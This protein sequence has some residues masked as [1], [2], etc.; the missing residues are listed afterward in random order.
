[1][2]KG[3]F[4]SILATYL[5]LLGTTGYLAFFK[6]PGTY[7]LP[8]PEMIQTLASDSEF[9]TD[10]LDDVK[11]ARERDR[12]LIELAAQSFN[13]ILGAMLG[14]LSAI[15]AGQITPRNSNNQS[16]SDDKDNKAP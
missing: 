12:K 6:F 16:L 9:K 4:V 15:A 11:K 13:V 10:L 5:M 7:N 14:F 3:M 1:M 2:S 8:N